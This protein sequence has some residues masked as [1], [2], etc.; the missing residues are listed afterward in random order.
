MAAP[1]IE[2]RSSITYATHDGVALQGDLYLPT[3][4]RNVPA[5]VAVH[6]GG[7]QQGARNAFEHWGAHLAAHGYA[8]FAISYRLAKKGHKAFPQ[9]VQDV[10]AAVQFVRGSA[11]ELGIDP[12]RV[13]LFGASAGAHLGA[14]A[15]LGGRAKIFAGGYP[16]DPHAGV[17]TAV[18]AFVGVYGVYDLVAMWEM[19]RLASPL[20]NNIENFLGAAPPDDRQL[21]FDASPIS[22]ATYANNKT[23][24]LLAFGTED[25]LVDRKPHS[26]AFL[27]ALKQAGFFARSCVVQGAGHYWLSDPLDETGSYTGFFAPRLLR[28]LAE[29]L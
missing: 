6:G 10:M 29:K 1:A 5:L 18:K 3:S 21:Y 16:G 27:K 19:Y 24:V 26:E 4:R 13:A 15:A 28:F 14:L 23:A 22:Y 2:L 9:A 11:G 7:W 8:L 17:D 25:D 20:D 12:A